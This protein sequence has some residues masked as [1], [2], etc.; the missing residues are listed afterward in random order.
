MSG[1]VAAWLSA[2]SSNGPGPPIRHRRSTVEVVAEELGS[3]PVVGNRP[4]GLGTERGQ[5]TTVTNHS[6]ERPTTG[7]AVTDRAAPYVL[8]A[9]QSRCDDAILPFKALA[10]DTGGL[11]SACEFTLGGWESWPSCTGTPRSTRPSM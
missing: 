6:A 5:P 4:T 9:G 7:A 1:A 2:G 10:S 11:L 3:E 8:A